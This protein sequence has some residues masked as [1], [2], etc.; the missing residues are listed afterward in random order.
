MDLLR[1]PQTFGGNVAAM[2]GAGGA[3]D[4]TDAL[5]LEDGATWF[6][7]EDADTYLELEA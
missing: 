3:S 6:L 5:L 4:P 2:V 7:C 1:S